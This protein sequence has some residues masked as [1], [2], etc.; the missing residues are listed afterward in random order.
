MK[1]KIPLVWILAAVVLLAAGGYVLFRYDPTQS[2]FYPKC[3]FHELTGW[4]CPGCGSAR[5]FHALIH[6]EILT[7]LDYNPLLVISLPVV[8]AMIVMEIIGWVRNRRFGLFRMWQ[9][10]ALIA[11]IM[12]YTVLRNLPIA[13]FTYLAP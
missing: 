8:A 10:A 2:V 11:L 12:V 3:M 9:A 6:G 13:P 7:A 5:A 1:R 4:Y